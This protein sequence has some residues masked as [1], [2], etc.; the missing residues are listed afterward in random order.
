MGAVALGLLLGVGSAALLVRGGHFGG[1]SYDGWAG[2]PRVGSAAAD[3]WTRAMVAKSGLL[4]LNKAETI[5][6]TRY[7]DEGGRPLD[8]G[9]AYDLQGGAMPAR[10][11]SVTLY[12]ADDYLA[13]NG[14]AAA[15]VDATRAHLGADGRWSARIG[16]ARAAAADWISTRNAGRFSLTL[17]L[18]NPTPAA[19][20]DFGAVPFPKLRRLSCEGAR[21]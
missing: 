5:Y 2:D 13:R 19:A 6:F 10:W 16:P 8:A 20:A 1:R 15:S 11:W 9:C 7:K 17:R 3:P 4:A 21:T 12:A 18:Y 14:D